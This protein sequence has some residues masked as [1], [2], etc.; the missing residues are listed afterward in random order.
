MKTR[1]ALVALAVALFTSAGARAQQ[2]TFGKRSEVGQKATFKTD[3]GT[4]MKINAAGQNIDQTMK[5]VRSAT[6]TIEAVDG[7]GRPTKATY[8]FDNN[9]TGEMVMAGQ[10]QEM[11]SGLA[12]KTVTVTRNGENLEYSVQLDDQSKNELKEMFTPE[13]GMLPSKP[14]GV[15]ETWEVAGEDLK[16]LMPQGQAG[17]IDAKGSGKLLG[18]DT[19]NGRQ[20]AKVEF[21]VAM[22]GKE[23][24]MNVSMSLSGSGLVDVATSQPVD[25]TLAGP[26]KMNGN[27]PQGAIA[28]DGTMS[29]TAKNAITGG[30]GGGVPPID[31]GKPKPI[32]P[33]N[34][35]V[36]PPAAASFAGT[37]SDEKMTLTLGPSK[38]GLT[39]TI[40]RGA[41]EFPVTA[42]E[43][44]NKL[45]GSFK[46]GDSNFDFTATLQGDTMTFQTGNSTYSLKR[47][48]AK[49]VNP[50]E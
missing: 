21:T 30:G 26:M 43:Q 5:V 7:N 10:R 37:F 39:G 18:V 50:L 42:S 27:T 23:G 12:G 1:F 14:I 48:A 45:T 36:N 49:P 24:E 20:V 46:A 28:V 16:K 35:P 17:N 38:L 2:V 4:Q 6:V 8:V 47:H 3:V 41:N 15:G 9:N 33:F 44:G 11:A 13:S 40:K 19:V 25:L 32:D 22:R 34:L 29:F 31:I